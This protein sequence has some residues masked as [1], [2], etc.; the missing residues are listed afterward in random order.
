MIA[1]ASAGVLEHTVIFPFDV[2]KTRLQRLNP[3]PD[4]R[5]SGAYDAFRKMVHREG[6]GSLFR[7]IKVVAVVAGPAHALYFSTYEQAKHT[8]GANAEGYQHVATAA[9]AV[10]ATIVHDA[11][12][13][14]CEVIKQRLQVYSSPYTGVLDCATKVYKLE[15]L[16]AF[17]RSYSIQL[18]MNIPYQCTH[19]VTYEFLRRR[20][21]PERTYDP[22][23][24]LISGG[25]AGAVAAAV[26]TP[27]DVAKTLLNTQEPCPGANAANAATV[28]GRK[29][30]W[31]VLNAFRTIYSVNGFKGFGK[32]LTARVMFA[33]PS[34]A[35]SWS[36]YEF[37]K[38]FLAVAGESDTD[39]TA[40][41]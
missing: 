39:A 18:V 20:L 38:Q 35:I 9:A 33:S 2:V 27:F 29:Y 37:I 8:F 24:H 5:Y 32:G 10:S 19:L 16:G 23:T 14:P 31:G 36:V 28:V 26:T 13:N 1:G 7:G 22:A 3:A 21:N 12:M 34:T 17:Y 4:A 41:Y 6:V 40:K 25:V 11:F 15:G 30:V